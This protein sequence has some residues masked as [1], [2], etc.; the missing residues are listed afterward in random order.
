[1]HAIISETHYFVGCVAA[2]TDMY[3]ACLFGEGLS[4][5]FRVIRVAVVLSIKM[6]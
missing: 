6:S 4:N 3:V 5:H 1:M 2:V